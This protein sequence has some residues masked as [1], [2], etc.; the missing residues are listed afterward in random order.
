MDETCQARKRH[1]TSSRRSDRVAVGDS[2]QALAF[3]C[4]PS[5][6]V[7]RPAVQVEMLK[8]LAVA[9]GSPRM[10]G[11]QAIDL[12]AWPDLDVAELEYMHIHKTGR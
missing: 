8:I 6:R 10:A 2:L 9:C 3:S 1:A 5:T 4:L 12:A 7:R 11:G